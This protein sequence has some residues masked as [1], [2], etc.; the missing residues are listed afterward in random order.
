[1]WRT[2]P[3]ALP[4]CYCCY[5][6]LLAINYCLPLSA[7]CSLVPTRRTTLHL[8]KYITAGILLIT[9]MVLI[10]PLREIGS[11]A[12]PRRALTISKSSTIRRPLIIPRPLT[13]RKPLTIPKPPTIRR[14]LTIP[15]PPTIRR[16]M[17]IPGSVLHHPESQLFVRPLSSLRAMLS[18]IDS[19]CRGRRAGSGWSGCPC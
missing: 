2:A 19:S 12:R 9:R 13:I 6:L 1:M 18:C 14:P 10:A 15:T 3:A 4:D 16:P 11:V 8:P 7:Y 5:C 17:T